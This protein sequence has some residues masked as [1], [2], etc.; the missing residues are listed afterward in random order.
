MAVS[1]ASARL[2]SSLSLEAWA[3]PLV[4]RMDGSVSVDDLFAA[5]KRS[6]E[7]PPAITREDLVDLVARLADR[8]LLEPGLAD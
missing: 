6:G 5:A 8:G 3:V 7:T 2:G 4:S 1:P